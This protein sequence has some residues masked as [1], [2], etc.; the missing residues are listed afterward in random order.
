MNNEKLNELSFID[1]IKRMKDDL[2][3]VSTYSEA[4][5]FVTHIIGRYVRETKS[6]YQNY[7]QEHEG[8]MLYNDKDILDKYGM[9]KSK[10]GK[11]AVIVEFKDNL[12]DDL[13]DMIMAREPD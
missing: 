11:D 7:M 4:M 9:S 5:D 8:S 6:T 2:N 12:N 3:S 13:F 1:Y 10:K